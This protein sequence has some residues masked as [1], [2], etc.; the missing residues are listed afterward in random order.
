MTL[1]LPQTGIIL[2]PVAHADCP[3]SKCQVDRE[4]EKGLCSQKQLLCKAELIVLWQAQQ[5][6]GTPLNFFRVC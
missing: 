2:L 1:M 6:T 4:L 3:D 5:H